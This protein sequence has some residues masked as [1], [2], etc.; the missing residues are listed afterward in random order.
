[1]KKLLFYVY[2]NPKSG[3]TNFNYNLSAATNLNFDVALVS[4]CQ[5]SSNHRLAQVA[6]GEPAMAFVLFWRW[7]WVKTQLLGTGGVAA[8]SLV[9]EPYF[10]KLPMS[11]TPP[12]LVLSLVWEQPYISKGLFFFLVREMQLTWIFSLLSRVNAMSQ[13]QII[14][15]RRL[16]KRQ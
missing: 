2:L 15:R 8:G 11:K 10:A 3:I 6:V 14:V 4:D 13:I 5:V 16:K 1:M 12:E 7:V 9:V